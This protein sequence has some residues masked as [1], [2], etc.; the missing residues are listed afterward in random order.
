[1][2]C[3]HQTIEYQPNNSQ[4]QQWPVDNTSCVQVIKDSKLGLVGVQI[5]LCQPYYYTNTSLLNDLAKPWIR[6]S[7]N[8]IYVQMWTFSKFLLTCLLSVLYLHLTTTV[9]LGK[10]GYKIWNLIVCLLWD[11]NSGLLHD[12]RTDNT[13]ILYPDSHTLTFWLA[14][15]KAH[16]FLHWQWLLAL[17][18][19][20]KYERNS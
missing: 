5:V 2:L 1:M 4:T 3:Q 13:L 16:Y 8:F 15:Q 20:I 10:H 11:T 6:F 12:S 7:D 14:T 17:D 9:W 18:E 19:I